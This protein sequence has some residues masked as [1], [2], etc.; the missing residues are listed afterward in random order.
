M[1]NLIVTQRNGI[2]VVDSRLIAQN[3]GIEHRALLQSLDKHIKSIEDTFG[4]V[5]FEMREFKTK[6]GNRSTEKLAWL[7][8]EQASLLMTCSRN[9]P[10]VISCKV[11]LVQAFSKAKQIVKQGI[12]AQ[13]PET[14]R[15]KLELELIRAKQYY[16]DTGHAMPK[17]V[18]FATFALST[19]PAML[20]WLRGETPPPPKI[21]YRDRFIDP[22][23]GQEIGTSSGRS[24]TQLIADAGLNP[25][26]SKDR[27]KVKKILKSLGF[28]YD[29]MQRWVS[30][31]YLREYPVLDDDT[32][33]VVLRAVLAE[34]TESES[35]PNLFVHSLGQVAFRSENA[36]HNL[37][38][39]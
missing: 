29:K 32:Y 15:M 38:G 6:Q 35:R 19:S 36:P 22:A 39:E 21:E 28:D 37:K 23:T 2:L 4:A 3:L 30:A 9:T 25:K 1:S 20:Q 14:E 12:S 10:Q 27:Q 5:A 11:A 31:S 16:Q 13:N 33:Q 26:S 17:A 24:L 18:R 7:T 8:E 34:V